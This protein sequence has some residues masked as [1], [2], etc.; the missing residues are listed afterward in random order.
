VIRHSPDASVSVNDRVN[1]LPSPTVNT[2]RPSTVPTSSA[3]T[4]TVPCWVD[5]AE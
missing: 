5:T 3:V 2:P 1:R 4:S